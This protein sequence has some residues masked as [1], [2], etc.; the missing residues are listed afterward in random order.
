MFRRFGV[1]GSLMLAAS[2]LAQ[3][4]N[5]QPQG[6]RIQPIGQPPPSGPIQARQSTFPELRDDARL[7]YLAA[8]IE[9]SEEQRKQVDGLLE[10]FAANAKAHNEEIRNSVEKL[11][12]LY[13][14]MDEATK[15]GNKQR[16]DEIRQQIQDFAT[17]KGA[18]EEFIRNLSAMLNAE[19]KAQMERA[20][21]RLER[22]P[23]GELRPVDVVAVALRLDLNADQKAKLEQ[24]KLDFRKEINDA[25]TFT[26]VDRD[27]YLAGF[28][29]KIGALLTEPQATKF[30]ER[31]KR[32]ALPMQNLFNEYAPP[33]GG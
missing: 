12:A 28:I 33:P 26:R 13:A 7:R 23:S 17:N 25:R 21:A 32:M 31:L 5:Q 16:A 18:E 3:T 30:N 1:F 14:E 20:L 22:N 9:L 19:Q 4:Q 11:R 15:A 10:T 2:A 8:Q 27:R 29:Q 6:P 24:A